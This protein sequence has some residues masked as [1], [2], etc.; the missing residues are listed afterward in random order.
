MGH[1]PQHDRGLVDE[2]TE[3]GGLLTRNLEDD[4]PMAGSEGGKL[5]A[6][7]DNEALESDRF[8]ELQQP[9]GNEMQ[10]ASAHHA[11][12]LVE[13]TPFEV[14]ECERPLKSEGFLGERRR[15]SKWLHRC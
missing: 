7:E 5:I 4:L 8:A 14:T 3:I 15:S 11:S 13:A 10:P 1:A 6:P 9:Q 12:R 2:D